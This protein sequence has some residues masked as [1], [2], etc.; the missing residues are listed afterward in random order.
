MKKGIKIGVTTVLY[1]AAMAVVGW[2]AGEG[3][4]SIIAKQLIDE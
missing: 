3:F 2:F 4:G 1:I